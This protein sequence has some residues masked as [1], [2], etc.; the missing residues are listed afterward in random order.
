MR[1]KPYRAAVKVDA[2]NWE[3]W[4]LSLV[5]SGKQK[6]PKGAVRLREQAVRVG[7]PD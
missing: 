5:I 6:P 3:M 1:I 7:D 2:K 4:F